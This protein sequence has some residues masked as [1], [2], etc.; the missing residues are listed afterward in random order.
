MKGIKRA[1]LLFMLCAAF[2]L[3]MSGCGEVKIAPINEGET[4]LE[5]SWYFSE[6]G[7]NVGYNLFADGGGYQFIGTVGNP[8]RYGIYNGEIYISVNGGD[9]VRF[10]FAKTEEGLMIAGL[11]YAPVEENPEVA[12]S[13]AAM[14]ETQSSEAETGNSAER[15]G[16]YISL[17]LTLTFLVFVMLWFARVQKKRSGRL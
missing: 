17:A 4:Y 5:G 2:V 3:L 14:M 16:L 6:G 1:P 8:I 12:E 11:L 7:L 10:D 13:I 9:A 15:I